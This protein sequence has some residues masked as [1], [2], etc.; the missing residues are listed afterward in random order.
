MT[1]ISFSGSSLCTVWKLLVKPLYFPM[2][3]YTYLFFPYRSKNHY[4][5]L[6][7]LCQYLEN[8]HVLW[9]HFIYNSI[10]K[11]DLSRPGN[12][13]LHRN[14]VKFCIILLTRE[15][16]KMCWYKRFFFFYKYS[17]NVYIRFF[18][19]LAVQTELFLSREKWCLH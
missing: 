4:S 15:M 11:S 3:P 1:L 5:L 14:Y 13:I 8:N 10:Y 9:V 7:N 19:W 2:T 18:I 17:V 12:S 16:I 6:T